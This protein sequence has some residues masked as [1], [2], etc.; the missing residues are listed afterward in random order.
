MADYFTSGTD[1][2]SAAD[3]ISIAGDITTTGGDIAASAGTITASGNITTTGGAL[4]GQNG[5]AQRMVLR[6]LSAQDY[7]QADFG[8]SI[9]ADN[10]YHSLDLSGILPAAAA[11]RPVLITIRINWSSQA[12]TLVRT[13]SG[14]PSAVLEA[15]TNS[16]VANRVQ[17]WILCTSSRTIEYIISSASVTSWQ[18]SVA[19]YI[20]DA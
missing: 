5:N 1:T 18:L 2:T 17:G 8:V 15:V 6:T 16:S 19:G 3:P 11:S 7:T 20:V 9:T 13:D 14:S 10:T 4:V 12:S